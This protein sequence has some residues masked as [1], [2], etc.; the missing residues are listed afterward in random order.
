MAKV[1][2]QYSADGSPIRMTFYYGTKKRIRISTGIPSPSDVKNVNKDYTTKSGASTY[3]H[4]IF[5]DLRNLRDTIMDE[6]LRATGSNEDTNVDWLQTII[7]KFYG[8]QT[9]EV[10]DKD[11]ISNY[12][13][14]YIDELQRKNLAGSAIIGKQKYLQK[15]L[16]EYEK[17][18]KTTL[19]FST[20]D[21]NKVN[22]LTDWLKER[23]GIMTSTTNRIR[24]NLKSCINYADKKENSIAVSQ[25]ARNISLEAVPK[26]EKSDVIYLNFKELEQI[27][28][29]NIVG[30]DLI[31]ARQWL[32][33]GC[34]TGQRVSD[35]MRM[36]K[37][38]IHL[39]YDDDG[40]VFHAIELIQQK[41]ERSEPNSI[42]IPLHHEVKAVLLVNNGEFPP[43]FSESTASNEA[44][45]NRYIKKV[46]KISTI[47]TIVRAKVHNEIKKRNEVIQVPKHEVVASHVCRRSFASNFYGDKRFT[48][49]QLMAITGHSTE[50]MY[51]SYIGKRSGD[52]AKQT[53]KVFAEI[54]R[55][56]NL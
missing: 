14:T 42:S 4:G 31:T 1:S 45:F 54:E 53:A 33:I 32:L 22:S 8:R 18:K 49:A 39:K 5:R 7:N 9:K 35:L 51:Q 44:L 2:Y 13:D 27:K 20:I 3:T 23:D 37:E 46:C 47:D 48:T 56:A 29:A 19:K 34:Y 25:N 26:S 6:Y 12:I 52:H 30:S 16:K 36:T 40:N 21:D 24:K 15:V 41:T 43:V 11:I 17:E 28:K 38:M 10:A 55:Q 50:L